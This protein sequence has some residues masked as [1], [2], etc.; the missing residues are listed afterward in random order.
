[1]N[2]HIDHQI[3]KKDGI[4]IFVVV[5]YEE[6][7]QFK[8]PEKKVYFPHEVV[9][10]HAI[11]EKSIIRAWREYKGISQEEMAKRIGITQA[12]LSQMENPKAKLRRKTLVKIAVAL[13][14]DIEQ[15]KI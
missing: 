10:K 12:A 7:L 5:P 14:V 15:L 3:I 1:M 13:E 8:K 9:E 11:E 6:Y 4:P 2:E